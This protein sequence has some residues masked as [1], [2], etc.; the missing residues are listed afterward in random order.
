MAKRKPLKY[1]FRFFDKRGKRL[2]LAKLRYAAAYEVYYGKRKIFARKNFSKLF[3]RVADRRQLLE[4]LVES[5]ENKRLR[6][7]ERKK[8][9]RKKAKLESLQ[10]HD[11]K[12]VE[13]R[14]RRPLKKDDYHK[15][16]SKM[17]QYDSEAA[18][19]IPNFPKAYDEKPAT[20]LRATVID[21]MIIPV[22]PDGGDYSKRLVDKEM[23]RKDRDYHLSILDFT[24]NE[25]SYVEL[26]PQGFSQ[27]YKELVK[28][29]I[30]HVMM[31]FKDTHK[32]SFHYI[33]RIKFLLAW[34]KES[35]PMTHGLSYL[36]S[37]ILTEDGMINLFR[38]TLHQFFGDSAN[39]GLSSRKK[40]RRNY[41]TGDSRI[42]VTGFTLEATDVSSI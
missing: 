32:S 20:A 6:I 27:Q 28:L 2:A 34:D 39:L 42:I 5:I 21:T 24:L 10:K 26:T 3:N 33:L 19:Q 9:Q 31:Y 30:P 7:I 29:F 36:R 25:S 15:R 35:T 14:I 13:R 18:V 4:S 37:H 1:S 11:K 40:I 8:Q 23:M 12:R 17:A 41:L 22:A 16:I 38:L